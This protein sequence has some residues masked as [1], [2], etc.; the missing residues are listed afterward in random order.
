M[1]T[2]IEQNIGLIWNVSQKFSGKGVDEIELFQLGCIGFRK[3]SSTYDEESGIEFSTYAMRL[4]DG[5]I[6]RSLG[7]VF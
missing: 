1:K 4:I 5:E 3:A 2:S 6:K 7:I